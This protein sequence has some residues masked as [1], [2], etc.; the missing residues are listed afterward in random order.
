MKKALMG[1]IGVDVK[2]SLSLVIIRYY[3]HLL[4]VMLQG[5]TIFEGGHNFVRAFDEQISAP[6]P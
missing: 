4:S 2:T 3:A 1:G 6:P 5:Q